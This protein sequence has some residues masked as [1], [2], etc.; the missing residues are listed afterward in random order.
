MNNRE[1]AP[2]TPDPRSNVDPPTQPVTGDEEDVTSG[3]EGG[4]PRVGDTDSDEADSDRHQFP[5][6]PQPKPN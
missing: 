2:Q 1:Q 6:P 5:H 4:G 3:S